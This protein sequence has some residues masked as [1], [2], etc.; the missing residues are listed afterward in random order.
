[1]TT[2]TPEPEYSGPAGRA[3]KIPVWKLQPH[4]RRQGMVSILKEN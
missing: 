1:M 4:G 2:I 3:G